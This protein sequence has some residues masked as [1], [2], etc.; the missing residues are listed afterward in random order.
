MNVKGS[1]RGKQGAAWVPGAFWWRAVWC[2]LLLLEQK[3]GTEF[4][5]DGG[6]VCVLL[7]MAATERGL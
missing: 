2:P 5:Q 7:T 4:P 3:S 6:L 1:L